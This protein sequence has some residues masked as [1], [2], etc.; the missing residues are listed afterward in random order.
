MICQSQNSNP[1]LH[2]SEGDAGSNL[3]KLSPLESRLKEL[4]D[5][6]E[7]QLEPNKIV[8]PG[9]SLRKRA[10]FNNVAVEAYDG[11]FVN[12]EIGGFIKFNVSKHT[13]VVKDVKEISSA[14]QQ[15]LDNKGNEDKEK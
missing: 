3:K 9:E 4:M 2:T 11:S 15:A 8:V 7:I 5:K 10:Q 1:I 6:G 14:I 13:F 12:I